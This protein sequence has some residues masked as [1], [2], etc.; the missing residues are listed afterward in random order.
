MF[1]TNAISVRNSSSLQKALVDGNSSSQ[2][3]TVMAATLTQPSGDG[4][5]SAAL[6]NNRALARN[7]VRLYPYC[8]D[9]NSAFYMRIWGWEVFRPQTAVT[10]GLIR[11]ETWFPVLLAELYCQAGNAASGPPPRR[12]DI[13]PFFDNVMLASEFFAEQVDVTR[14]VATVTNCQVGDG[15]PARAIVEFSGVQ[16]FQFDFYQETPVPNG[17]NCFFGMA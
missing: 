15:F 12:S 4:V 5:Y 14:G 7:A 3:W 16:L 17:M 8:N 2:S 10:T 13:D 6:E 11:R 9:D 1:E